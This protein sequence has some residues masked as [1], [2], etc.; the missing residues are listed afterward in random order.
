[1]AGDF[2]SARS[3]ALQIGSR[4]QHRLRAAQDAKLRTSICNSAVAQL[5]DALSLA[6]VLRAHIASQ[7]EDNSARLR[8]QTESPDRHRWQ[9]IA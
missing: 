1:M 9:F 4:A 2:D 6:R 5:N 3:L 8:Y 7:L